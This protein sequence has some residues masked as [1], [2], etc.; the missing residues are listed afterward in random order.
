[1]MKPGPN[2]KMSKTGKIYLACTWN[3][4][5]RAARRRSLIQSELY[6]TQVIKSKREREN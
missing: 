2:Y 5:N 3:R 6:G 4:S 1:M